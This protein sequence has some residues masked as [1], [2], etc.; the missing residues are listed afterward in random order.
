[1]SSGL[2]DSPLIKH[3]DQIG[4]L[5][6]TQPLG[7]CDGGALLRSGVQGFLHQ[8]FRGGVE[9]RGGFVEEQDA[10]VAQQGTSD[11]DALLLTAAEK[12]SVG[13]DDGR[14]GFARGTV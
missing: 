8:L 5:D 13:A 7:N 14:K 12:A 1:M 9:R 6:G 4:V 11:G 10:G 3:A 2:D